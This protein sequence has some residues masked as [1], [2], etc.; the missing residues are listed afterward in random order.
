MRTVCRLAFNNVCDKAAQRYRRPNAIATLI[1]G[2]GGGIGKS[3]VLVSTVHRPLAP[4]G[5]RIVCEHY[6]ICQRRVR[7]SCTVKSAYPT[8]RKVSA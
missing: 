5:V 6:A 7:V 8:L 3:S 2:H 1:H 4:G